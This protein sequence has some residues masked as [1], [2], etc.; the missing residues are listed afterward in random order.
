[1]HP[2]VRL[3]FR[4]GIEEN[5]KA[6]LFTN[7]VDSKK[8]KYDIPVAIGVLA[9]KRENYR[10]DTGCK[11]TYVRRNIPIGKGAVSGRIIR[12]IVPFYLRTPSTLC[13]C[14]TASE[15]NNGASTP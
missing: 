2:L 6:F 14:A 15:T 5:R 10:I 3:Q 11:C 4:G 13:R 9:A 7:V 8:R 1:M 12:K